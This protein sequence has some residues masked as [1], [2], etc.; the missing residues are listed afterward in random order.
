M[1][2][3]GRIIPSA[4]LQAAAAAARIT[5]SMLDKALREL[6]RAG[7]RPGNEKNPHWW[8]W[9]PEA[10]F[11]GTHIIKDERDV[12]DVEDEEDELHESHESQFYLLLLV[13]V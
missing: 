4:E 8:T 13:L 10:A 1:S 2:D 9:L 5:R 11:A 7:W 3:G 12:V 6:G